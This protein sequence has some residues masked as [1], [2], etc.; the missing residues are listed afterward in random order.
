MINKSRS[1]RLAMI[2]PKIIVEPDPE[3]NVEKALFLVE[4]ASKENI[5]L[6]LFPA[7]S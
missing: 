4:K 6:I 5:D 3:K 7:V 1:F 2:Q